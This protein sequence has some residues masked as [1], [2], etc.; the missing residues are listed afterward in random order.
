MNSTPVF[1]KSDSHLQPLDLKWCPSPCL[2]NKGQNSRLGEE[3]KWCLIT[4]DWIDE[5]FRFEKQILLGTNCLHSRVKTL[6]PLFDQLTPASDL[7]FNLILN[8]YLLEATH[9]QEVLNA[10]GPWETKHVVAKC[11]TD[12]RLSYWSDAAKI[13]IQSYAANVCKLIST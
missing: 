5:T 2:W 12:H 13:C 1:Q 4:V 10:K 11:W 3:K 7:K 9:Q 6:Q 8:G